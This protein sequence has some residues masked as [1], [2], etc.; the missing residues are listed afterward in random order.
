[1]QK[2]TQEEYEEAI[3][4]YKNN[5]GSMVQISKELGLDY[6]TLYRKL[7]DM[8][9]N[10]H[11]MYRKKHFDLDKAAA[12]VAKGWTYEEIGNALGYTTAGAKN[13][14]NKAGLYTRP[15]HKT[16]NK[17]PKG[18]ADIPSR[19]KPLADLEV[20]PS[21]P[22]KC[23][24]SVKQQCYYGCTSDATAPHCEY[25]L[26]EHQRRGC[27]AKQCTKYITEANAKKLLKGG[28]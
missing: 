14:M 11:V 5:E 4:R 15:D 27:D 26:V 10:T 8:G 16:S 2:H 18:I 3:R 9:V 13:R 19:K 21:A 20:P 12:L 6:S 22:V 28:K 24:F 1:M 17:K 23:C 7:K 25:I